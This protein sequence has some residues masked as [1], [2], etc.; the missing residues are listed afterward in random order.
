MAF[1]ASTVVP[2]N[3][4]VRAK[5]IAYTLDRK[6]QEWV[7]MLSANVTADDVWSWYRELYS[8]Y[9]ALLAIGAIPGIAEYA[10]AQEAD[11]ELDIVAEFNAMLAA[12]SAAYS[13]I[14][15]ALP[16]DVDGWLLTHKSTVV[17]ELTPRV[18]VPAESAPLIPLL[19][20]VDAAIS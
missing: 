8:S 20:A 10:I 1:P 4:Y 19:Q 18:F 6:V 16:R 17:G 13:W 15:V 14:Y 2:A 7:G 11:T 9:Q 3:G 12:I 5:E